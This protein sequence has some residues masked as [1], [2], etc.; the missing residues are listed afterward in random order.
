[1]YLLSKEELRKKVEKKREGREGRKGREGGKGEGEKVV[2]GEIKRIR[3][4]F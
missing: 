3:N 2:K 1:M 4:K